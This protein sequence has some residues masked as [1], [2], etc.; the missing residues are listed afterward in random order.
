MNNYLTS[1]LVFTLSFFN[2]QAYGK[3]TACLGAANG[4]NG[5]LTNLAFL[6][7]SFMQYDR[8]KARTLLRFGH[9][10]HH[11]TYMDFGAKLT[12]PRAWEMLRDRNLLSKEEEEYLNKHPG[13]PKGFKKG[14]QVLAWMLTLV[15]SEMKAGRIA[16]PH[17]NLFHAEIMNLRSSAGGIRGQ[18]ENPTPFGY[19][20]S[21]NLLLYCWAISVGLFFAGFLSV[22]G[23]VAYA[24]VVYIFFNL[25]NT[26]LQL[27]E[28]F[29]YEVRHLP[30]P[31][32]LMRAYSDHKEL[33]S[34]GAF[35]IADGVHTVV[36]GGPVPA[37]DAPLKAAYD[38]NFMANF[39]EN[40]EATKQIKFAQE[41]FGFPGIT[42]ADRDKGVAKEDTVQVAVAP[43]PA[44]ASPK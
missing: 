9:A 14:P 36:P 11:L 15:T 30:V 5:A 4:C 40:S 1:L 23:S 33:L 42:E 19:M 21:V 43:P 39:K 38:K 12:N 34:D 2:Q 29:G 8:A 7:V 37:F 35:V 31:E 26:G 32:F 28:P 18:M 44:A 24:L 25:R 13:L 41:R 20:F 27:M 16:P 10:F 22:Y 6:C 17:A 3:Y